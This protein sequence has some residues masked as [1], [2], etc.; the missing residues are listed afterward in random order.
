MINMDEIEKAL[1]STIKEAVEDALA[2]I[3]PVK[4]EPYCRY[5]S[6]LESFYISTTDDDS[7]DCCVKFE[8]VIDGFIEDYSCVDFISEKDARPFINKLRAAADLI[9]SKLESKEI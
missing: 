4:A 8:D 6:R 5:S 9:E 3:T 7:F 2:D 1:V